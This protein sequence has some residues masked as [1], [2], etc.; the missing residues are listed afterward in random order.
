MV[1]FDITCTGIAVGQLTLLVPVS[2]LT[3]LSPPL[4]ALV[5]SPA[6]T[7]TIMTSPAVIP[8]APWGYH[9]RPR[10]STLRTFQAHDAAPLGSAL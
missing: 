3:Q 6:A 10:L 5:Y 8:S 4:D 1:F 7:K 9:R 2:H